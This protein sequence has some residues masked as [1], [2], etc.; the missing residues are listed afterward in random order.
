MRDL[1]ESDDAFLS[2]LERAVATEEHADNPLTPALKRLLDIET[3][4]R[5]RLDKLLKISDGYGSLAFKENISLMARYDK[6]LKRLQKIARISDLYQRTMVEMNESLRQASLHDPLTGL[7]NRRYMTERLREQA[8][9]QSRDETHGF[10][11]AM[12]DI[13]YF[14]Q[15]NDQFG[16]EVGD[17]V[18]CAVSDALNELLREY[19]LCARWGGEE[20]LLFLPELTLTDGKLVTDRI[21]QTI[22]DTD[23]SEQF[24][25][26]S[27]SFPTITLSAGLAEHLTGEHYEETIKRADAALFAAKQ[28]GRD[29]S[30][31]QYARSNN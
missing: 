16:H 30:A 3:Q 25:M 1:P 27:G 21:L 17:Q 4:Q 18:I 19:D 29:Q 31:I 9:R 20:F 5:Q 14:K 23:F 28:Q 10:L 22:R 2:W 12:L 26:G 7:P 13:D 24:S 8:G 15:I 6:Q 11:L